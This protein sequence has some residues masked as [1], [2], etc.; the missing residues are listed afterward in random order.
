MPDLFIRK[1]INPLSCIWN[2]KPSPSFNSYSHPF[3][4]ISN[5]VLLNS[6]RN[7]RKLTESHGE[8]NI[9]CGT[10]QPFLFSNMAES[11]PTVV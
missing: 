9:C 1:N 6:I 10:T 5:K 11:H 7:I 3:I 8:E 4:K 2:L